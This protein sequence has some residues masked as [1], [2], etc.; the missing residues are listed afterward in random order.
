[1]ARLISRAI[2]GNQDQNALGACV[3]GNL[4]LE[5]TSDQLKANKLPAL[6]VYGSKEGDGNEEIQ[7]AFKHIASLMGA[8]VQVIDGSDHV[9]TIGRPELADAIAA[10][11]KEPRK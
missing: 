9:S 2:I 1:V 4:K 3:R 5:V 11:L 10:F 7:K 6:V 8:R